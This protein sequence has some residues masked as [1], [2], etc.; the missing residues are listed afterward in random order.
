MMENAHALPM[1]TPLPLRN[2][3]TPNGYFQPCPPPVIHSKFAAW[4]FVE[5]HTPYNVPSGRHAPNL[6]TPY[7]EPYG[8]VQINPTVVRGN[9]CPQQ[10]RLVEL[11]INVP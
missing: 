3:H 7:M 10:Y 9:T 6:E 2:I 4:N 8:Q 5:N 1:R 11:P